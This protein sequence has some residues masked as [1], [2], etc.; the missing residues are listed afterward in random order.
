MNA[1]TYVKAM[2]PFEDAGGLSFG[3]EAGLVTVL[4]YVRVSTKGQFDKSHLAQQIERIQLFAQRRGLRVVKIYEEVRRGMLSSPQDRPALY[5]C[6]KDASSRV[7][8]IVA[9]SPSRLSRNA[10][11]AKQLY[12]KSPDQFMFVELLRGYEGRPWHHEIAEHHA[13]FPELTKASSA[14]AMDQQK[15]NGRTFGAGDGGVAGCTAVA[16]VLTENKRTRLE[17]MSD[18]LAE[19]PH[20]RTMTHG[21][22]AAYLNGHGHQRTRSTPQKSTSWTVGSITRPLEATRK[23]LDARGYAALAITFDDLATSAASS[24]ASPNR[25]RSPVCGGAKDEIVVAVGAGDVSGLAE[26]TMS[27]PSTPKL[28]QKDFDLL[29]PSQWRC[30]SSCRL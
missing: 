22:A 20:W 10:E 6:L 24:V 28:R 30:G 16:K 27:A 12:G 14:V 1:H 3:P 29:R 15:R 18:I 26:A 2:T 13:A 8:K 19:H 5:E 21:E 17:R 11:H 23:I 25:T 9:A 7:C 4:G